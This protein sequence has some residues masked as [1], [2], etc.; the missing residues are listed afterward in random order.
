STQLGN[1]LKQVAKLIKV[2][3][4]GLGLSRQIFFCSLGG[5]DT[6]SDQGTTAG[7]QPDLLKTLNDAMGAFYDATVELA[8]AGSVTTVTM[9]DFSRTLAPDGTGDATGTDHAWGA[10]HLVMGD[11]VDG[12][13]F[14]GTFPTLA[15]DGPDDADSGT[16]ARGRWIPTTA[17]DQYGAT[18]AKWFG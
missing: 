15:C 13:D 16:G 3:S 12:G 8:L 6:H 1:Q 9:S 11:A 4:T 18:L 5:F 17:V 7:A 2:A 14:Y 10:H